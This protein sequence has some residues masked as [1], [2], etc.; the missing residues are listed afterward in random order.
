MPQKVPKEL[1][2]SKPVDIPQKIASPSS[3]SPHPLTAS[4]ASDSS[5]ASA[6]MLVKRLEEEWDY[7]HLGNS[8]YDLHY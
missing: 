7:S 1:P 4:I 5:E 8:H 6:L 3:S 2:P